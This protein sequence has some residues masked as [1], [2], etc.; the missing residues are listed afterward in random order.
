MSGQGLANFAS[1]LIGT[2]GGGLLEDRQTEQ[3]K[4]DEELVRQ[5]AAYHALLDHPDTLESDVPGIHDAVG[6]LLKAPKEWYQITDHMRQA[7]ARKVPDG[8]ERET[9]ASINDRISARTSGVPESAS[10]AVSSIPMRPTAASPNGATVTTAPVLVTTPAVLPTVPPEPQLYQPT[11]QYG[12]FTL[13][14]SKSYRENQDYIVRQRARLEREQQLADAAAIA[15]QKRLDDQQA[16][17]EREIGLRGEQARK[18]NEENWKKKVDFLEPQLRAKAGLRVAE[19]AAT[20]DPSLPFEE[21]QRLA[22]ERV[23]E[24]IQLGIEQKKARIATAKAQ[25][26]RVGVL[27]QKTF[28]DIKKSKAGV[29]G[30]FGVSPAAMREYNLRTKRVQ[31]EYSHTLGLLDSALKKAATVSKSALN[32]KVWENSTEKAEVDRLE[33]KKSELW[34]QLDDV[35]NALLTP[36]V[37]PQV[38]GA[39]HAALDPALEQRIRDAATAKG[40]DPNIAVQRARARQ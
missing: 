23:G 2:L 15:A 25:M 30:V 19:V 1:G 33:A 13:G 8:P 7:M 6:N 29:A 24:E 9:A 28:E 5:L 32:G 17:R 12:D 4:K 21:R 18:T 22:R 10:E 36:R 37:A 39:P 35:A 3:K 38:P 34:S 20:L 14:E 16:A 11:R 40:L 31:E 27:N 26:E